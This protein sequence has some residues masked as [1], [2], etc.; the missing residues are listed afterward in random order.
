MEYVTRSAELIDGHYTM[1]LPLKKRDVN[2]P[3]NRRVA[4]QRALSLK[5]RF[6][7]DVTFH[8]DYTALKGA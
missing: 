5:K 2:M 4:E 7:K 3:N 1:G 8:A 6:H